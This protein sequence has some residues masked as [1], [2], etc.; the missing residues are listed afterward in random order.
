[1]RNAKSWLYRRWLGDSG[2]IS[3]IDKL[4]ENISVKIK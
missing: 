1:M 4:S 2:I 3:E